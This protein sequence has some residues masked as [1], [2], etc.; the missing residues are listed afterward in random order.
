VRPAFRDRNALGIGP[1]ETARTRVLAGRVAQCGHPFRG[2]RPDD[3]SWDTAT[4]ATKPSY[5]RPLFPFSVFPVPRRLRF[6]ARAQ[7][8][9]PKGAW[10]LAKGLPPIPAAGRGEPPRHLRVCAL[11]SCD[12][13]TV[14][15][16]LLPRLMIKSPARRGKAYRRGATKILWRKTRYPTTGTHFLHRLIHNSAPQC[17]ASHPKPGR[18]AGAWR[19][20]RGRES[21]PLSSGRRAGRRC[22][23]TRFRC[24]RRDR[25]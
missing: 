12:L 9:L 8:L 14:P 19:P 3:G 6:E 21:E 23:G 25:E 16:H 17:R 11:A 2:L 1:P 10:P 4:P 13:R 15:E 24:R 18:L 20:R 22:D 7:T 5:R